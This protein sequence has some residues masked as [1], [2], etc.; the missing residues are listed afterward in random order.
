MEKV[1]GFVKTRLES[2]GSSTERENKTAKHSG[3]LIKTSGKVGRIGWRVGGSEG[4]T[5]TD[6]ATTCAVS[7]AAPTPG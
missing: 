2:F 4:C 5:T 6:K 7:A 1:N 3:K